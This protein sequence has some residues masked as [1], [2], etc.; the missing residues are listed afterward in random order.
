MRSS[1]VPRGLFA[2][3]LSLGLVACGS[4][5]DAPPVAPADAPLG[6]AFVADFV[7]PFAGR[8]TGTE[9]GGLS[10]LTP[11]PES[12]GYIGVSDDRNSPRWFTLRVG[13]TPAGLSVDVSPPVLAETAARNPAVPSGLDFESV[14]RLPNGDLLIGSEGDVVAGVRYPHS[15]VRFT[16]DGRFV[17]AVTPPSYYLGD[18]DGT[19]AEGLRGNLG[20]EGM[21]MAPDGSRAWVSTEGPLAQDDERP[22]VGRGFRARLLELVASGDTFVPGRELVYE[23]AAAAPPAMLGPDAAMIAD[24]VVA[25][26]WLGE[27]ELLSMERSFMRDATT[28]VN[29]VRIYHVRLAGAD[30]VRGVASLRDTAGVRAVTKTLVLDLGDIAHQLRPSLARLDNFEAMAWG[31]TLPD[32]SRTLLLVSDDNFSATQQNAFVLLRVT[33]GGV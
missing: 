20:F 25:L 1:S 21:A 13:F 5:H 19:P 28:G 11:D 31:P 22:A 9:F 14:G 27:D 6:L 30:D 29:L 7:I 4:G 17:G 26:L 2:A 12:G 24:G 3:L 32:G 33:R 23:V 16:Q 10:S 18:P 15:I 8:E